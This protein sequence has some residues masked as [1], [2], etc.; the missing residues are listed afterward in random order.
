MR[1]RQ[2]RQYSSF[3]Q[4]SHHH[5]CRTPAETKTKKSS[6]SFLANEPPPFAERVLPPPEITRKSLPKFLA[7][8]VTRPPSDTTTKSPS[9]IFLAIKPVR[10]L[11]ETKTS[12]IMCRRLRIDFY[13]RG[14]AHDKTPF[15]ILA[16]DLSRPR[17]LDLRKK[18][19]KETYQRIT[20][21]ELSWN[22]ELLVIQRAKKLPEWARLAEINRQ[23]R[24]CKDGQ[25][26]DLDSILKQLGNMNYPQVYI[27][28]D[29]IVS[30]RGVYDNIKV[31]KGGRFFMF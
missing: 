28:N 7:S 14:A 22:E 31:V 4:A 8:T 3:Q 11:S 24:G 16:E 15:G 5:I 12:S 27:Y 2:K 26:L 25:I 30:Y 20:E 1:P 23:T 9:Q 6:Q 18:K 13:C 29:G 17:W 21:D 10:T 19:L